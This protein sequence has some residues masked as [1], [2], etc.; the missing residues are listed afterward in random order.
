MNPGR[1]KLY[2][3]DGRLASFTDV[4]AGRRLRLSRDTVRVLRL[5]MW[6][7]TAGSMCSWPRSGKNASV[8]QLGRASDPSSTKRRFEDQ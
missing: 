2:A 4:T 5:A 8:P 1:S 6:T 7:T 3:N